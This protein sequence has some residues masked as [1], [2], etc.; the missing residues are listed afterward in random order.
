MRKSLKNKDLKLA[1]GSLVTTQGQVK[2]HI[3]NGQYKDVVWAQIFPHVQKQMILR[4][5]WLMQEYPNITWSHRIVPMVR[6]G[7]WLNLLVIK[8]KLGELTIQ[9]I[10]LCSAKQIQ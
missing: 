10:S 7:K 8:I 1:D 4:M 5:P 6:G 3:E 2:L 9:E